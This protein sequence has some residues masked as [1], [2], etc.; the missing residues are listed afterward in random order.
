MAF[1]AW[2]G[3]LALA[4][5][6]VCTAVIPCGGPSY[7]PSEVLWK[8][9]AP[10]FYALLQCIGSSVRIRIS[11]II[12]SSFDHQTE[13]V[14]TRTGFFSWGTL[15]LAH[16]VICVHSAVCPV[17]KFWFRVVI[18]C[19]IHSLITPQRIPGSS[20]WTKSTRMPAM[21]CVHLELLRSSL[22]PQQLQ[23]TQV[24]LV[25]SL[26]QAGPKVLIQCN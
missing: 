12:S 17:A 23:L 6:L 16:S 21:V 15:A 4:H 2:V 13:T 14:S 8:L 10:F 20:L 24:S 11:L 18:F 3:T 22:S 26:I 1:L 5:S 9:Y 7:H 19:T 25:Y